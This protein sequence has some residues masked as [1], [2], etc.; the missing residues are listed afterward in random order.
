MTQINNL[1]LTDVAE[2][3]GI[4]SDENSLKE[5]GKW[6]DDPV[7]HAYM[8]ATYQNRYKKTHILFDDPRLICIAHFQGA[9]ALR[10]AYTKVLKK[11]I[12]RAKG[13]KPDASVASEEYKQWANKMSPQEKD[14]FFQNV[15][16]IFPK[17]KKDE[18]EKYLKDQ[19]D[20]LKIIKELDRNA[21]RNK[22]RQRA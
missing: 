22:P 17:A 14:I 10:N 15:I 7:V 16:N 5:F 20:H 1:F 8:Y 11:D 13:A 3:W 12:N 6:R 18:I 2:I 21:N 19:G 4:P 9:P